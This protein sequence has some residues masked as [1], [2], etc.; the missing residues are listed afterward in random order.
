M[1]FIDFMI[2]SQQKN[3]L[4]VAVLHTDCWF[5]PLKREDLPSILGFRLLFD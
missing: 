5:R 1:L 2:D 3:E 4:L